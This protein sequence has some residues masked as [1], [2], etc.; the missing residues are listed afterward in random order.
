MQDDGFVGYH[1]LTS[2]VGVLAGS[3]VL[4]ID[5]VADI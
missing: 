3:L 1:V 5:G 4:R 2:T